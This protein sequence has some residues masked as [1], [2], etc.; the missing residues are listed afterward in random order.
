[1]KQIKMLV[2]MANARD[3]GIQEWKQE[4]P[5]FKDSLSHVESLKSVWATQETVWE[6]EERRGEASGR[7][8]LLSFLLCF[9]CFTDRVQ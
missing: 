7:N 5:E 3:P 9:V 6:E 4:D 1:M 8:G 2:R